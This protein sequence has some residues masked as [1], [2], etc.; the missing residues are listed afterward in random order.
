M[1]GKQSQL[2]SAK[3]TSILTKAKARLQNRR[4]E[5]DTSSLAAKKSIKTKLETNEETLALIQVHPND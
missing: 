2:N 3:L 5:R 1:G 4:H